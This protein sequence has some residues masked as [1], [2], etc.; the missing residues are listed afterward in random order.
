MRTPRGAAAAPP[1]PRPWLL[2]VAWLTQKRG[3]ALQVNALLGCAAVSGA[4][5]SLLGD[6]YLLAAGEFANDGL[7]LHAAHD[8]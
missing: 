8:R 6:D 7:K 4:L 2:C 1:R 5:A 3:C